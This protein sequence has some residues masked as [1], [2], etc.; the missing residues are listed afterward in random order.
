MTFR[1]YC[2]M[3][4]CYAV[5]PVESASGHGRFLLRH[6][7]GENPYY[8]APHMLDACVEDLDS[9][10]EVLDA[11]EV[12]LDRERVWLV[13]RAA[14]EACRAEWPDV[15]IDARALTLARLSRPPAPCHDEVGR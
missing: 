1:I 10:P 2:T 11:E 4:G 7:L 3:P 5:E 9:E 12:R 15:E 6:P 14:V 13:L 8:C